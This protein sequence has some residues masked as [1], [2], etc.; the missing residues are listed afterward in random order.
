MNLNN[1][2]TL[3]GVMTPFV[4]AA[5]DQYQHGKQQQ[6]AQNLASQGKD[7]FNADHPVWDILNNITGQG[8][9]MT[10]PTALAQMGKIQAINTAPMQISPSTNVSPQTNSGSAGNDGGM[11]AAMLAGGGIV[12]GNYGIPTVHPSFV[13]GPMQGIMPAST[14][15]QILT[16]DGGGYVPDSF[17]PQPGI[18]G[19][20]MNGRGAALIQGLQAGQNLGHNWQQ[21]WDRNRDNAAFDQVA[22]QMKLADQT[23]NPAGAASLADASQPGVLDTAKNAI[24]GFAQHIHDFTLGNDHKPHNAA[25]APGAIPPPDANQAAPAEPAA[26]PAIPGAPPAPGG[27]PGA[28]GAAPAP[29]QTAGAPAPADAPAPP[30]QVPGAPAAAPGAS[31]PKGA[32]PAVLGGDN[33]P[34]PPSPL[35]G[36]APAVTPALAQAQVAQVKDVLSDPQVQSGTPDKTPA[37][38]LTPAYWEKLNDLKWEAVKAAKHAGEDPG[39]VYESLNAMQTAHFQG[40]VI[41][42]AAVAARAFDNGD[43][44]A[45]KQAIENIN[46]YLPDGQNIHVKQATQQDITDNPTS[47]LKVGDLVH[48]NPYQN[49]PGHQGEGALIKIDGNYIQS[50]A[51]GALDPSQMAATQAAHYKMGIEA[52]EKFGQV[53]AQQTAALGTLRKGTGAWMAGM[54]DMEK[55]ETLRGQASA[56][57]ALTSAKIGLYNSESRKN[58]AWLPRL[59]GSTGARPISAQTYLAAAKAGS[60]AAD[61][62]QQG[63][64]TPVPLMG[65]DGVTLNNSPAAGHTIVDPAHKAPIFQGISDE[66]RPQVNGLAGEINAANLGDPGMNAT[67][68]ADTAARVVKF[69]RGNPKLAPDTPGSMTHKNPK[70]GAVE[71]N[72]VPNEKEGTISVWV[73]NS[74]RNVK[75]HS[76]VQADL[77]QG[78]PTSS[79]MPGEEGAP[80]ADNAPSASSNPVYGDNT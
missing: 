38:S 15:G 35:P 70:T 71:K 29:P 63:Q 56:N 66:D 17:V 20:P 60:E 16:M 33:T 10:D 3:A 49:M 19:V 59:G 67:V 26:G 50:L 28:A 11:S 46:Y 6:S 32:A 8:T 13:Q 31:P 40:Q 36:G 65:P 53:Q 44:A 23:K 64:R 69:N 47:G 73:G 54:S 1:L 39:K 5:G 79:N 61:S 18:T 48:N 7:Q 14:R 2:G 68:A 75:L 41:K 24:E 34:S 25:A 30:P 12:G 51:T 37:H 45:T 52:Q 80:T 22:D 27:A 77:P 78:M 21:A 62:A 72:V 55:Q 74:W 58:D 9:P 43:M 57:Q 4:A 42:Q 76:N